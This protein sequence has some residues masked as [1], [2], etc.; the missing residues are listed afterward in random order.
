MLS[1]VQNLACTF[2]LVTVAFLSF[3]VWISYQAFFIDDRI[4]HMALKLSVYI[5]A[6]FLVLVTNL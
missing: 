3:G 2:T 6:F 1:G 5:Y 4:Y